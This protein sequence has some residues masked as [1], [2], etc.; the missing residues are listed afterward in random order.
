MVSLLI[1]RRVVTVSK[2]LL[3]ATKGLPSSRRDDR[4][5]RFVLSKITLAVCAH[6]TDCALYI[7]HATAKLN[8]MIQLC[9][10]NPTAK[11]NNANII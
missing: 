5:A 3:M 8:A 1:S 4:C 10:P 7:G 2:V 9:S 11:D 6:D